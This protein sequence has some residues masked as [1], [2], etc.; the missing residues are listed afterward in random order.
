MHLKIEIVET[1]DQYIFQFFFQ[2]RN[3][4]LEWRLENRSKKLKR[5]PWSDF[6]YEI[7]VFDTVSE[8]STI[9]RHAPSHNGLCECEKE[10]QSYLVAHFPK[11]QVALNK[12]FHNI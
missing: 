12:N 7:Q 6:I 2:F 8:R 3:K 4:K 10:I 11:V 9:E 5:K 1:M